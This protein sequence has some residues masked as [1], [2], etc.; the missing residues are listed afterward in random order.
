MTPQD[1]L[2]ARNAGTEAAIRA[3]AAT[4]THG[5]TGYLWVCS[6]S[7]A[8]AIQEPLVDWTTAR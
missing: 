6:A 3:V 2:L 8:G 5:L 7:V 1:E 4:T